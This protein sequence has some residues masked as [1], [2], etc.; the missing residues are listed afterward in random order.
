VARWVSSWL[1]IGGLAEQDGSCHALFAAPP[2]LADWAPF[3]P[4]PETGRLDETVCRSIRAL[5]AAV[6]GTV[7]FVEVE[8][9]GLAVEERQAWWSQQAFDTY[10]ARA[11]QWCGFECQVG[12][13]GAT[14]P[15]PQ[16][17]RVERAMKRPLHV[18]QKQRPPAAAAARQVPHPGGGFGWVATAQ[19]HPPP[20]AGG[21]PPQV[22]VFAEPAA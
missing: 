10:R 19:H 12:L 8:E 1:V 14:L 13:A 16:A 2:A 21:R 17:W 4:Q 7:N 5:S 6:T 3:R 18:P 9:G 11:A 22:T 15:G 20:P